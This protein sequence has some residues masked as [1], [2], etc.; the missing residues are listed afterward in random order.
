MYIHINKTGGSSIEKALNIPFSHE[1]ALEKIDL[2]GRLK[3]GSLYT[4]AFVRNPWDKVVSHYR[5]RIKTNQTN[6]GINTI[7][8][9]RW[10]SLSHREKNH[11]YY[12]NPK[13]FMPQME[14]ISDRHGEI[15][16][17]F[18]GRFE[19]LNEDFQYIC[20][21][22]GRK[23]ILPHIKSSKHRHYQDYYD[24]PTKDIV[25]EWFQKDIQKFNYQF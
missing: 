20:A 24:N 16:V 3:W 17:D 22:I 12:D 1:T 5:Y 4:F 25:A 19:N 10:V 11:L 9:K 23:A 2:L 7:D 6:L 15:S 14:W 18:V 21:E 13:M 8:F